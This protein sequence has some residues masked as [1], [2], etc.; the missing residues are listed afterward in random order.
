MLEKIVSGGQTGADEAGLFVANKFGI[1][2]GG[3]MPKG[4]KTSAGN[5]PDFVELY[6]IQE[7]SSESYK[8]RTFKNVEIADATV[9]IAG[10]FKSA[11]ER[12]TLN[13]IHKY[14][15][16]YFDVNV[17]DSLNEWMAQHFAEWLTK[18]DIK[19]LNVAGNGEGTFKGTYDYA[20]A[21]L[22]ATLKELGFNEST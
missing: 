19:V 2:T 22:T 9:R 21:F 3:W 7:H 17:E 11:G 20:V 1:V 13:A 6:N 8:P 18:K 5:R 4:F 12:C 14:Q 16:P 15:K 10:N